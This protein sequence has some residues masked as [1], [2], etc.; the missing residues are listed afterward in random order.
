MELILASE[1]PRRRE[2]LAQLGIPFSVRSAQVKEVGSLPDPGKVPLFNACLKA[3]AVAG[4]YPDALVLGADTVILFDG[5]IIGKPKDIADAEATL[6]Q[7][8]GRSH[9]V[10][11]GLALICVR[12]EIRKIWSEVTRVI[13]KPF[14][15]VEAREYLKLVHVL[16][17]AG[18]YAIQEH[19]DR[20]VAAVDG[21]VENVVGLPI[22]RLQREL[23]EFL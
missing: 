2:L 8:S 1:S 11:T 22:A 15:L 16:D 4:L 18:S 21:S 19:S 7:L 23:S 5:R 9:E 10:I 14:S 12:R 6:M 13:F 20:I 3:E 17:K